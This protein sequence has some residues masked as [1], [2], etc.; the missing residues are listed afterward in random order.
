MILIDGHKHAIIT[1]NG[2]RNILAEFRDFDILF[3][4]FQPNPHIVE[5]LFDINIKYKRELK[6]IISFTNT[7]LLNSLR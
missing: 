7:N 1:Q 4:D 5:C 2:S 3:K 6:D